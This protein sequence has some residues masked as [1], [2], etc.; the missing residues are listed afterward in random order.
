VE[1]AALAQTSLSANGED[2]KEQLQ[3]TTWFGRVVTLQG[4]LGL[5]SKMRLFMQKING[6]PWEL[7]EE[8][9]EF[10]DKL[11]TMEAALWEQPSRESDPR[12]RSNP[13]DPIPASVFPFFHREPDPKHH[14]GQTRIQMLIAEKYMGQD[15]V[16]PVDC[17]TE[18]VTKEDTLLEAAF[19]LSY[20]IAHR[21]ECATHFLMFA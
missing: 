8:Q 1:E 7:M 13:P 4:L 21:L 15:L 2:V 11:M 16:V 20:D 9:R 19:D 18:G 17:R 12:W 10:Y 3:S 5:F 14:P 6:I